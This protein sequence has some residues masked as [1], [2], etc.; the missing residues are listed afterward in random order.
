MVS[1]RAGA[2]FAQRQQGNSQQ[3]RAQRVRPAT[4]HPSLPAC[5]RQLLVECALS[6]PLQTPNCGR[7]RTAI[8][9][10]RSCGGTR[11]LGSRVLESG[12]VSQSSRNLSGND[13]VRAIRQSVASRRSIAGRQLRSSSLLIGVLGAAL[14]AGP[15]AA[16]QPTIED[17]MRKIDQLQ[18]RVDE[19]ESHQHAAPTPSPHPRRSAVATPPVTTAPAPALPPVAVAAAPAPPPATTSKTADAATPFQNTVPGLL[20]PEPMGSQFENEDALR[21][22]LPGVAIRIPG[23]DTRCACT[24]SRSCPATTMSAAATRPTRRRRRPFR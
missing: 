19:L 9:D 11:C 8:W 6:T 14:L 24:A 7:N 1:A 16:Q 20:P 23:T 17:L 15:A 10:R 5:Y 22:D 3:Q 18:R 12:N 13:R 4:N 2:A 21:S